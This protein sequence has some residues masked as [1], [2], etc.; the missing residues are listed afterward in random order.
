[1]SV[2]HWDRLASLTDSFGRVLLIETRNIHC[3]KTMEGMELLQ[4]SIL[5]L[6]VSFTKFTLLY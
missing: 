2:S 5:S 3:H 6:Q 4:N 1:M